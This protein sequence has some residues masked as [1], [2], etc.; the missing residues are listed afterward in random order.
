MFFIYGVQNRNYKK[1]LIIKGI[2]DYLSFIF[3]NNKLF[4]SLT[5]KNNST[6][7]NEINFTFKSVDDTRINK[8]APTET[9]PIFRTFRI[10]KGSRF[11]LIM[12]ARYHNLSEK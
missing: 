4:V 12:N 5:T 10:P 7:Y 11:Y 2:K 8:L 3:K 9:I 1:L 6:L